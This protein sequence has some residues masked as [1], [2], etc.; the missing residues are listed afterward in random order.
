MRAPFVQQMSWS[1]PYL[2]N[3]F[4]QRK[5]FS[6]V[7]PGTKYLNLPS[8]GW[9]VSI[10]VWSQKPEPVIASPQFYSAYLLPSSHSLMLAAWHHLDM[11]WLPACDLTRWF[12]KMLELLQ[13]HHLHS[14]VLSLSTHLLLPPIFPPCPPA[15]VT[16]NCCRGHATRG[17]QS[18]IMNTIQIESAS[19][20]MLQESYRNIYVHDLTKDL[21]VDW[22][23]KTKQKFLKNHCL[24]PLM[25]KCLGSWVISTAC[26]AGWSYILVW[27]IP[28]VCHSDAVITKGLFHTQ[29]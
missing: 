16:L 9:K 19:I 1:C 28:G 18:G 7:C 3:R 27:E 24:Y 23:V 21:Q 4:L 8:L 25:A 13:I 2:W 5:A 20:K 15:I 10:Q 14:H 11:Q 22:A 17:C 12:T 29:K 26:Q 6:F